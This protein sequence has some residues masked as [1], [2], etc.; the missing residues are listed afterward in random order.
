[1]SDLEAGANGEGGENNGGE[2]GWLSSIPENLREHE[3]FQ[4]KENLSSVFKDY[5]DLTVKS[6]DLLAIPGEDAT[7]E[8]RAAFYAKLGRPE[9]AE[10]YELKTP[11]GLQEGL[12]DE[13]VENAFKQLAFES[14][15]SGDQASKLHG[16]YWNLV[17]SGQEQSQQATEKAIDSLKDEW[18]GD[19]FKENTEL[20]VRA[21]KQFGGDEAQKFIE[22]TRVGGVSLGDHPMFLKIFAE[23]G[24]KI[25]DDTMGGDRSGSLDGVGSDEQVAKSRFPNTKFKT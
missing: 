6:K 3:A 21:F 23:I 4:G 22:E 20:A 5:A 14:G 12:H 13:A 8:D 18:K 10:Q 25:G 24:K 1:M 2:K 19:A 15:L 7:D 11:E 9:A 17:K 16:W